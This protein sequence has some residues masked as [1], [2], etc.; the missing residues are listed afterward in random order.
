M[1]WKLLS[2]AVIAACSTNVHAQSLEQAVATALVSNPEVKQAFND[3]KSYKS[4]IGVIKGAYRPTLDLNASIG[5]V[6]TDAASTRSAGTD[7]D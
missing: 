4:D 3:Y 1:K 7:D 6:R 5:Q 2:L